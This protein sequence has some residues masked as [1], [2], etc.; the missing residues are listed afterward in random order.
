MAS[1]DKLKV[2]LTLSVEQ[3]DSLDDLL[4]LYLEGEGDIQK[5]NRGALMDVRE[6]V[7]DIIEVVNQ[8]LGFNVVRESDGPK[9]L[10]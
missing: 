7:D 4:E 1:I 3:L 2:K 10:M 5:I 6:S 9:Y 8:R